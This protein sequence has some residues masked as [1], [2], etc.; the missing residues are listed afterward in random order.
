[1]RNAL[2]SVQVSVEPVNME[3]LYKF[4]YLSH[5][6]LRKTC[7]CPGAGTSM[8]CFH[9][10]TWMFYLDYTLTKLILSA[11]K[12]L[13]STLYSHQSYTH[14][15][16]WKTNLWEYLQDCQYLTRV[17]FSLCCTLNSWLHSIVLG[18]IQH[19]LSL[20]II[21][22]GTCLSQPKPEPHSVDGEYRNNPW[23]NHSI[24]RIL[25]CLRL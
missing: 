16:H 5:P 19:S 20:A 17:L 15:S 23:P 8:V 2:A 24:R 7:M 22:V 3:I 12:K 6:N 4:D 11:C 9:F 18:D 25:P 13:M 14:K 10:L 21:L 1:M